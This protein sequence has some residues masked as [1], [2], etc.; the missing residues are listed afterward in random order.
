MTDV[1]QSLY[2]LVTRFGGRKFVAS[3]LGIALCRPKH[4]TPNRHNTEMIFGAFSLDFAIRLFAFI[5]QDQMLKRPP[6][7]CVGIQMPDEKVLVASGEHKLA[8]EGV[9]RVPV[10]VRSASTDWQ[11][12]F[13][14]SSSRPRLRVS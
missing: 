5:R 1:P 13:R 2:D 4:R 14:P 9:L 6:L 11:A 12:A 10:G 8:E 7:V 3:R